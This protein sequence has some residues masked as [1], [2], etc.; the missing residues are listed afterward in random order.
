M[1][2]LDSIY[3]PEEVRARKDI[4]LENYCKIINIEAVT[5]CEITLRMILPAAMKYS[6][7]LAENIVHLKS[8]GLDAP[9][10]SEAL[11]TVSDLLVKARAAE[12]KLAESAEAVK[13][14]KDLQ[15]AADA[16]YNDVVAAMQELRAHCDKLEAIMPKELWPF[17]TYTDLLLYV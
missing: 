2:I 17:P 4:L 14:H 10:Q 5:M 1:F 8:L 6:S 7:A 15:A 12:K 3:T 13:A 16:Y 11:T 9:V